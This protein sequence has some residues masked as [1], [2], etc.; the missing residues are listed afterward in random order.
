MTIYLVT[1]LVACLPTYLT[2][3]LPVCLPYSWT[4][5]EEYRIWKERIDAVEAKKIALAANLAEKKAE[6][7]FNSYFK[8][9]NHS[10]GQSSSGKKK[11]VEQDDKPA[12]IYATQEEAVDAFKSLLSD[13]KVNNLLYL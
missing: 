9:D 3:C 11:H 6:A 1:C 12:P 4:V 2:T 7:S 5:P 8:G 10:N 13:K